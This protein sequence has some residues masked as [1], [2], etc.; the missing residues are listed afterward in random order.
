M[1]LKWRVVEQYTH[2]QL[3][4]DEKHVNSCYINGVVGFMP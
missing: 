3:E 1:R 4:S 2:L